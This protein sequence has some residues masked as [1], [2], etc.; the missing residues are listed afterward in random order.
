MNNRSHTGPQTAT[1]SEF[2]LHSTFIHVIL[3]PPEMF[4]QL[5]QDANDSEL[6]EK[7]TDLEKE[8][9]DLRNKHDVIGIGVP[10][11]TPTISV[12]EQDVKVYSY[13]IKMENFFYLI[14][15]YF[16]S[17]NFVYVS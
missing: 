5:R 8:V 11:A 4:T 14:L 17:G 10:V 13:N 1:D 15:S 2:L 3:L 16:N 12:E 6:E 9:E 7:A